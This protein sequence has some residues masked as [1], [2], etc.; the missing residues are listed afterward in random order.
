MCPSGSPLTP[1]P[2]VGR[3]KVPDP[4]K[5]SNS[6]PPRGKAGTE[7]EEEKQ[8]ERESRA[9]VPEASVQQPGKA[10]GARGQT[11]VPAD[12]VARLTLVG[13][14]LGLVDDRLWGA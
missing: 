7:R 11:H 3:G 5:R 10:G 4:A 2:A 1:E 9:P 13:R 8:R 14:S 6:V 12:D